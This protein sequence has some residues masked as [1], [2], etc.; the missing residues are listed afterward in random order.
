[1]QIQFNKYQGAGNDFII[2]DNRKKGFPSND[3]KLI[4]ALCNRRFGIG[5][6]G[7]ILIQNS[8]DVDFEMV[9]FNS[10]GYIGSMCGNGG[11]CAYAFCVENNIVSGKSKFLASDGSHYAE[12]SKNGS[13]ILSMN[14]VDPPREIGGNNFLNTGSPHYIIPVPDVSKIDVQLRGR[15]I[16]ESDSFSPDG[17][18]VNFV[19]IVDNE[20][21]IRTYERGVEDE[22]LACGTGIT[23]AAISSRFQDGDGDYKVKVRAKG[24]TLTVD[25]K[26]QSNKASRVKLTGPAELVFKGIVDTKLLTNK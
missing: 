17:T 9:Y 18:N 13:I 5:A 11:R 14:D 3:Y 20:L 23:A 26:I 10:D 21:I 8:E 2:I 25:F 19:E 4:S 12:Y 24:G 16:R 15:N 1:M 6:D 7:L 22:T